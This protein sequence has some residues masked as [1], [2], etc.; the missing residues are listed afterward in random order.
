MLYVKLCL[1]NCGV[2]RSCKGELLSSQSCRGGLSSS[3]EIYSTRDLKVM[4]KL[5]CFL[6]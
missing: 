2:T 3:E 6:K 5:I 1:L 4:T